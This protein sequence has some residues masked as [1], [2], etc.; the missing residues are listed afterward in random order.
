MTPATIE[1]VG[2]LAIRNGYDNENDY[3]W[4]NYRSKHDDRI[5]KIIKENAFGKP[6]PTEYSVDNESF[7]SLYAVCRHLECRD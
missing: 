6:L 5:L 4:K 2:W 3:N 1:A 7:D